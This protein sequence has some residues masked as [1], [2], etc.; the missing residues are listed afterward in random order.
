M[1]ACNI[2]AG[3]AASSKVDCTDRTEQIPQKKLP[4]TN[5]MAASTDVRG[6]LQRHAN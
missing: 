2:V 6:F 5:D 1:C 4:E 3:K